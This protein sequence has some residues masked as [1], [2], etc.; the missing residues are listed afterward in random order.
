MPPLPGKPLKTYQAIWTFGSPAGSRSLIAPRGTTTNSWPNNQPGGQSW[1]R[2]IGS[3]CGTGPCSTGPCSTGPCSTGPCSTGP[4]STGPSKQ[5]S[6]QILD[7]PMP[8]HLVE[9]W[10]DRRQSIQDSPSKGPSGN[11]PAIR[12]PVCQWQ[13]LE[14]TF[15]DAMSGTAPRADAC[16]DRSPLAPDLIAVW[17]LAFRLVCAKVPRN[18]CPACLFQWVPSIP[19]RRWL[20]VDCSQPGDLVSTQKPTTA[21]VAEP[22]DHAYPVSLEN[23]Q[24]PRSPAAAG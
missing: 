23:A 15:S 22:G 18:H 1:T 3:D 6:D 24:G 19:P 9:P 10:P 11:T 4:C 20:P 14:K 12:A 8:R 21:K 2:S 7:R 17:I 5:P 16:G 13:N